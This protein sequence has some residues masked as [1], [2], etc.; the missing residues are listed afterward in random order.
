MGKEKKM[1][2]V[3]YFLILLILGL[4][5]FAGCAHMTGETAGEKI[6]DERIITDANAVIIK[7]PDAHY[8]KIE[9]SSHQGDVVLTGFV[10]NHETESR[11]ANK[12]RDIRGVKSVKSLL[13]IEQ[14]K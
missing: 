3:I 9:V 11:L 6:D 4:G 2:R 8:F 12:I 13:K 5:L 14:K 10:N 7:D 1:K